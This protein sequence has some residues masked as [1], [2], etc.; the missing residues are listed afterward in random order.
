MRTAA[1]STSRRWHRRISRRTGRA[2]PRS[3]RSR[4]ARAGF[5][6][7]ASAPATSSKVSLRTLHRTD[8]SG[9]DSRGELVRRSRQRP[10]ICGSSLDCR[11]F[12]SFASPARIGRINQRP[13]RYDDVKAGGDRHCT[14]QIPLRRGGG[15]RK[16]EPHQGGGMLAII[17]PGEP[18]A[19]PGYVVDDA[20]AGL[21]RAVLAGRSLTTEIRAVVAELGFTDFTY[22]MSSDAGPTCRDTRCFVWSTLPGDWVAH[23]GECGYIETDPA[24]T[25][26]WNRSV[27]FVWD[28]SDYE[29][30]ARCGAYFTDARRVGVASGV[31]ISFRDRDHGRIYVALSSPLSPVSRERGRAI[32][33][34]LGDVVLLALAFHDC[35]MARFVDR[36]TPASA[37]PA[38]AGPALSPREAQ[39][40]ELAAKGMTS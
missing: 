15:K 17:D 2:A 30:D 1:S 34:C 38:A 13:W 26:S 23:Y 31:S 27:P 22:V 36:A 18:A 16:E 35:F 24:V 20:V 3:M 7:M 28:A 21:A 39:C 33:R 14:T 37:E 4:C 11:C 6:I 29:R 19:V 12:R 25:R 9:T 5:S 32:A 10:V 40:L 8:S